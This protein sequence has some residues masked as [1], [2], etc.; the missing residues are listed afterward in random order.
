MTRVQ[1]KHRPL[2]AGKRKKGEYT[3]ANEK[4][5]PLRNEVPVEETWRLEDL[6]ETPAKWEEEAAE[7]A[8]LGFTAAK[9]I[10]GCPQR[11]V[12]LPVIWP[13]MPPRC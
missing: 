13:M 4:R 5:I 6:Y 12:P 2:T 7:L 9:D 8:K 11:S 10:L 3:M 1:K